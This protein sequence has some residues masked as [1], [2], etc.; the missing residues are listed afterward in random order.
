MEQK[1]FNQLNTIEKSIKW[2]KE[3]DSMNGPK[4]EVAYRNL[5]DFRR[6]FNKKKFALEGNPAAA[7]YGASQMGKSY[8][9]SNLLSING[10]P[11][12]IVDGHN[13]SYIYLDEINPEGKKR[14]ATSLVT[15]FS[16]N[17]KWKNPD[18][19][20][21]AKLLSPADLVLVLCD[22][23]YND[24]K[25]KIDIALKDDEITQ[26]VTEFYIKYESKIIQQTLFGEDDILDIYDYFRLN[27]STKATN[28]LNSS[29]FEKIP[30]LI[31]KTQPDD[32]CEIFALLWNNNLKLNSIFSELLAQYKKLD[33]SNEIYLTIEAVLR[34]NGTLL[35]VVRLQEIY[36]ITKGTEANHKTDTSVL[37][38]NNGQEKIVQN[39]S[40]SFLCAL[41][42]ELTFCLPKELENTKSFLKTTDLLD[43]PGTRNRLGRH[44]EEI[45][46]TD[47][48]QMLLRGKVAYLFNKY[49]YSEKINILL[50]CQNGE[51]SE[52]QNILPDLLSNW[53]G[54]MI[55]NS[56][57]DRNIFIEKSKV[58]PLFIIST[59]FNIDMQFDYNN[60]KPENID[61]RNNRWKGRFITVL[62]EV[63]GSRRWLT[64]WT[65][66]NMSFQNIYLLRDF[67][68]SSDT[69]S[70]LF[71]GY[72]EQ[73]TEIE[74]I[75]HATYPNFRKDL[76]QSFTEYDFVKQHF[77][78]PENSWDRAA[79][80]NEDGTKLIIEKLTIA[81]NNI[82]PARKE[83]IVRELKT[84]SEGVINLLKDY[85]NSSDKADSLLRA[86]ATAGNIQANLDIAF[87]LDP[88]FFGNMIKEMMLNNSDVYNLFLDKIRDIEKQDI[89]NMDKYSGIRM[90]VTDLNSNADF[91]TNLE[92]LRK[93]YE[94][95]TVE[96]CKD[97][98]ENELKIDLNELFYGNNE[99]VKNFSDVLAE[100]L[101]I[102]WF[103]HYM[104]KNQK[105]LASIFSE[106]GLYQIQNM[107]RSLFK[108]LN[109]T[110]TIAER[111]RHYVDGYRNI[112]DVYE[113]IAD[114]SAEI[115]NKFINSV[116][117]EYYN[118][119]NY[120]DLEKA[121]ENIN[122][123][124]WK[125][126]ELQ[127]K[128]NSKTEVG[129]LITQMGN[130][131]ELLNRNPLPKE[132]LKLLPNFR[133]YIIWRD[134]LKSGFVTASGVPNYDPIANK[135]LGA[136][137]KEFETI[138]F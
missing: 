29:F 3:T 138:E 13:K 103:E 24:V 52:V 6:K 110:K 100:A 18:F 92:C 93:H 74:E 114:I 22:S 97:F 84:I 122:G 133:N 62:D 59:M 88:Y 73:K 49:S 77:N 42:A 47:I 19:P 125:H 48:P 117:L 20:V 127:F 8:L 4:G 25:P 50:F 43:F 79:N 90:N 23:Y 12:T 107:L 99:R 85:Y 96:D 83:K 57:E 111:I 78:D 76:R 60:D 129:E 81:A 95:Q 109:V 115:I 137:I 128:Q 121:S 66:S 41:T 51:K 44:E 130:L 89:V 21:K 27:F 33:F 70:K 75:F 86:I 135:N 11:F 61:A 82:N 87:G 37:I 28:A 104:P 101:E 14:E 108:K 136:I 53:I 5:V 113:M 112:E 67:R 72:N 69:E 63:F 1:I 116:G 91:D 35:D 124:A 46:D 16:T 40:K 10:S 56:M 134:L 118:E 58:P 54:D 71:K 7:I 45:V 34:I 131:P 17:Y 119:S 2:V 80:I 123:L 102:F 38:P 64:E 105:N 65:T 26:K 106:E 36:G 30:I 55:G 39:Y 9:V 98:F 32:W 31:S 120:T 94:K 132:E 68:F 15:R 126:N